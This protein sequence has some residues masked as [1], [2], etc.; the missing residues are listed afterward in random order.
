MDPEKKPGGCR[1]AH[2][3]ITTRNSRPQRD[4]TGTR[5]KDEKNWDGLQN[6][7]KRDSQLQ[8]YNWKDERIAERLHAQNQPLQDRDRR[9]HQVDWF[10]R[11]QDS[12]EGGWTALAASWL[13][14]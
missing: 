4:E 2:P 11:C 12:G 6:S 10:G 9:P 1:N 5:S 7:Q 14:Q 8:C 13:W 3:R